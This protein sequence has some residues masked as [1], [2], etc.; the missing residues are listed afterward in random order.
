MKRKL[1]PDDRMI[2]RHYRE[3]IPGMSVLEFED[4]GPRT[5]LQDKT[6]KVVCASCNGGWMSALELRMK[7]LYERLAVGRYTLTQDDVDVLTRW[8][9]KTSVMWARQLPNSVLDEP[10]QLAALMAGNVVPGGFVR[11]VK[12]TAKH[13][14]TL[15]LHSFQVGV[16]VPQELMTEPDDFMH[17]TLKFGTATFIGL[18]QIVMLAVL[19]I[20]ETEPLVVQHLERT[21]K[22]S[23]PLV[24]GI[25]WP[26]G[27]RA[28]S[29]SEFEGLHELFRGKTPTVDAADE[30][31][32]PQ[33]LIIEAQRKFALEQRRKQRSEPASDGPLRPS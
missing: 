29:E 5:D 19:A 4:R 24:A 23:R 25:Q 10:R 31:D 8:T 6:V 18:G 20:D 32:R 1:D 17:P 28:V 15:H 30:R 13:S 27:L 33:W 14:R 21:R 9:H 2:V 26:G 22:L 16:R 3:E 11:L 12:R 7:R